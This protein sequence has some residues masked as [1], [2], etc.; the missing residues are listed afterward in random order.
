MRLV[1]AEILKLVRRR[2]LMAWTALLTLGPV[3]VAY[4]VLLALHAGSPDRHG[5]AG[6]LLNLQNL[7]G[8]SA[9]IGSIAGIIL[10]TTAG[11]QDVSAGVFR[12]LVVT[13]K[14]RKTLFRVR[15]AGAL[16]VFLPLYVLSFVLALA[17]SYAF[18]GGL[19]TASAHRVGQFAIW[20]LASGTLSV[21]LAVSLASI[22][23]SRIATGVL[24]AWNTV[25]A[26]LLA[27]I[28]ALGSARIAL[29]N[30]AAEHFLPVID[31]VQHVPMADATAGFVLAAW[32]AV[33]LRAGVFATKR[34]DA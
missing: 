1:R 21:V 31:G 29:P 10:G 3:L 6:G 22:V 26:S 11:S 25:L 18:A 19:P 27:S 16:A 8:V 20:L 9:A 4:A 28:G 7:L 15:A 23:P 32:A 24:V 14:P 34:R 33:A 2:G 5:P 30:A 12:D 13:G 17:G